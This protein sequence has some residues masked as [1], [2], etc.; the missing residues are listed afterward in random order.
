MP[1]FQ[2]TRRKAAALL[3][4]GPALAATPAV[5]AVPSAKKAAPR[6]PASPPER[7]PFAAAD[8][9]IASVPGFPDARFF[10][11]CDKDFLQA[12]QG[13]Q[14]AWL[15]LS[16]GGE[17]GAFG[18]GL[19]AGM[20]AAG[21][22]PEFAL[23]TGAST[24]ALMAPFVFL[25][26]RYDEVLRKSYTSIHAGDI[27]ELAATPESL[28]DTWPLKKL[29]EKNVTP[30]L[31]GEIAAEHRKGRRL[32]VVTTNLD[33]GRPVVWNMGAIAERGG[34]KAFAD[35]ALRLFRDI[36]LASSSI[37]GFFPPVHVAVEA[38]GKKFGEMHA[39]GSIRA[40]FY[41]APDGV[42]AGHADARLAASQLY[43]LVNNKLST[44]FQMTERS[45]MAVLGRSITVALKAGLRGEILRVGTAAQRH[46]LDFQ[47]SVVPADFRFETRG[48]FD[49]N[50]MQA[51]FDRGMRQAQGGQAFGQDVMAALD[52][53][54][55]VGG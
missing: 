39:D 45:M 19:L 26:A 55:G 34:D 9:Q 14:G 48:A 16:G 21:K 51:L 30:Q 31:L 46:G 29:I 44:D 10:G 18:A 15:A 49:P 23:I 43:V 20:S 27:F 53:S 40:P 11:D 13:A 25:G 33:A 6:K 7:E 12:T 47:L 42:L 38:N 2:P 35:K 24:G 22:R 50:Y 3:F 41:V 1:A 28:L 32:F 4:L 37:P 17:D 36:L 8:Q 54:A 5:A 52:G